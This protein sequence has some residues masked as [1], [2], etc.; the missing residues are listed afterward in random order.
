[1]KNEIEKKINQFKGIPNDYATVAPL[2]KEDLFS[3][4]KADKNELDVKIEIIIS[5]D[6]ET[7]KNTQ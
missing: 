7:K 6:K 1:M 4:V 5:T 3:T 2:N